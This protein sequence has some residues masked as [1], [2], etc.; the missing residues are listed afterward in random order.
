MPFRQNDVIVTS[1]WRHSDIN[2]ANMLM[3]DWCKS[4]CL[5]WLEEVIPLVDG[6]SFGGERETVV[7]VGG[8]GSCLYM[9]L[10]AS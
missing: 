10:H 7:W 3:C 5:E 2:G 8:G 4:K 1:K 6:N 9:Q